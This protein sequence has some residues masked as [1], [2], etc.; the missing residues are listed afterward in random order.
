LTQVCV[1]RVAADPQRVLCIRARLVA[2]RDL[3][4]VGASPTI[5]ADRD[6]RQ[7][8]SAGRERRA[9]SYQKRRSDQPTRSPSMAAPPRPS[10]RVP[11][12]ISL[13]PLRTVAQAG[14]RHNPSIGQIDR[15]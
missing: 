11:H 14:A 10:R 3:V 4:V 1:D 12:L 2:D 5:E 15:L 6:G 9:G 7:S 8:V 13:V